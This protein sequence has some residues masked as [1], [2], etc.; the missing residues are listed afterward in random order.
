M[1][2]A[3]PQR[4]PY[5]WQFQILGFRVRVSPF[6]WLA[7]A[8]LGWQLAAGIDEMLAMAEPMLQQEPTQLAP[9]QVTPLR[10][11]IDSNPGQGVLLLLW[12]AAVFVSILVHELGHT[13]AMR[14]YGI[15]SYVVLYHF[16]GLA[17]PESYSPWGS[18][19]RSHPLQQVAIS[20]AGP[21]AQ[22]GLA[23]LVAVGL[24][25]SGYSLLFGVPYL[26]E[27]LPLRDGQLI[28]S[29]PIMAFLYFL[30]LPS[31]FWA[32]LN[33][34][35]VYPLDGGQIAR[36]LLSL[37]NPHEGVRNSLI[38]STVVGGI[39]AAYGLTNGDMMLGMMFGMLAFSSY[40]IL[41]AYSGR[42]GSGPW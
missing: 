36:E 35:P 14:Y 37:Y 10:E 17:V 29:L 39:V 40:Q 25:L 13:F 16:G 3:E 31:I 26:E 4:T 33:L 18:G 8:L 9:S 1:F 5:D 22:L 23:A 15:D 20:A 42:G 7:A 19:R 27:V 21:G 24:K 41:Q 34:L 38:L 12:I 11:L 32:L 6:F 28:T 30:L 2:L